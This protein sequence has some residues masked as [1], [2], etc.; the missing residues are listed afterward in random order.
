[1]ED[2]VALT[3]R[4]ENRAIGTL[5][6]GSAIR[7]RDPLGEVNRVYGDRGQI[8]L[9]SPTRLYLTGEV[10][11]R[12]TPEA[13]GLAAGQWHELP[14]EEADPTR[15]RG[16]AVEGFARAVLDGRPPPVRAEDGRAALEVIVAAYRSGQEGRPIDLP[17]V[18]AGARRDR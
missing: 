1:V 9:T 12:A 4:Y 11:G 6:A 13:A 17:L 3:Y 5:E 16:S 7:G 8:V 10:A 2:Y 15:G 18:A 14:A